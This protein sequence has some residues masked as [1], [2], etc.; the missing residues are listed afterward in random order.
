MKSCLLSAGLVLAASASASAA[1]AIVSEP[2][3]TVATGFVWTGGYIG[4]NGGWANR[5]IDANALHP[6]GDG[7]SLGGHLGYLH[8]FGNNIV[9][10][11]EGDIRYVDLDASA[12]C[13]NPAFTCHA[14]QD[15]E[16]SIRAR[17][18]YAVDRFL[19]YVTGGVAFTHFEGAVSSA[20]TTFPDEANLTGW[21][22]GAGIDYAVTDTL[23]VGLE[24][25]HADYGKH[26]FTY[27]VLYDDVSVKTDTIRARFSYKF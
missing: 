1:D 18:G 9:L 21:T 7:L 5:G 3:P 16:A 15:W 13:D 10:G 24:Y 23:I 12:P 27:D 17:A 14:K 11:V 2:V 8:Q 19:P 26:D 4:I 6:D 25:L 20:V 22:L